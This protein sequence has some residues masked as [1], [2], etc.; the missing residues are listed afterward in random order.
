M[1]QGSIITVVGTRRGGKR[2]SPQP[3]GLSPVSRVS[4]SSASPWTHTLG[5]CLI[6]LPCVGALEEA[7]KTAVYPKNYFKAFKAFL[8]WDTA[9]LLGHC[10]Q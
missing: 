6:L 8:V 2:G 7:P 3:R 5:A 10:S 4:T 9:T 1:M